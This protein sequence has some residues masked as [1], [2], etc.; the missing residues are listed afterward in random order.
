MTDK[1]LWSEAIDIAKDQMRHG[2]I[3]YSDLQKAA[4][5]IYDDLLQ[6]EEG[7][8]IDV[9]SIASKSSQLALPT[10]PESKYKHETVGGKVRCAEC[11]KLLKSLSNNH[12]HTHN[13]MTREE[14]MAKHGVTDKDMQ[15]DIERKVKTGDDNALKILGYIMK[16]YDITRSEVKA[17]VVKY[18]FKDLK[19]LMAQAKDK[20]ISALDLLKEKAPTPKK[21]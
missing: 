4:Q 10:A 15:G 6:M 2:K 20:N 1:K 8:F 16:E 18:G 7:P 9:S 11:G 12:L 13:N 14:Y 17:F 21:G 5:A 3:H 19:D